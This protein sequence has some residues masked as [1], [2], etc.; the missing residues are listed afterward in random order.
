MRRYVFPLLLGSGGCAVLIALGIWQVQRMHWKA[1]VLAAIEA[2]IG[3]E[4]AGLPVPD[5]A[6]SDPTAMRFRPV[7]VVGR[8][9]GAEVLVLTG[10][11]DVGAG[12]EVISAFETSEGRRILLDRGFVP[13]GGETAERPAAALEIV[14][15]LH[16]PVE[17]DRYTPAPDIG[18]NLWFVRDVPTIAAHLETEPILVVAR[19]VTG[20]NQGIEP[21]PVD[22]SGIPNDHRNY[23]IT[24]FSLAAVWVGMTGYL[25]WRIRQK[26]I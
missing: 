10:K 19:E 15:N 8:T 25:L 2:Q 4:P 12:Y 22:T 1:G 16:W 6:T 14:G 23:A 11:K 5:A 13:Q 9:T 24:W 26:T 7:R 18:R 20:D 17:A 21:V 3:G